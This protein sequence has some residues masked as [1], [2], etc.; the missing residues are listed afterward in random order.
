M[1]ILRGPETIQTNKNNLQGHLMASGTCSICKGRLC[2]STSHYSY[3]WW[4]LYPLFSSVKMYNFKTYFPGT[5]LRD[6][7]GSEVDELSLQWSLRNISHLL[8]PTSRYVFQLL[9]CKW[10]FRGLIPNPT[11]SH[12]YGTYCIHMMSCLERNIAIFLL[13]FFEIVA[14]KLNLKE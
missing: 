14:S 2:K 3:L 10:T 11:W 5:G 4:L 9:L 1:A 13:D 7:A 8:L 12:I 6:R